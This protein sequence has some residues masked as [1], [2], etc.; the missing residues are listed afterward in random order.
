VLRHPPGDSL[1]HLH[2]HIFQRLRSLADRQ[3]KIQFLLRFIEQQQRPVVRAQKFVNFLHD[4]A[5]HLVELQG[6]GKSLAQ[7][8]EHGDFSRFAFLRGQTRIPA[9]VHS[10]EL[11]DFLNAHGSRFLRVV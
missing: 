11:F 8:L 5:Q 4:G 10:R 1:P 2:A 7:F 9:A 3:L 6:R